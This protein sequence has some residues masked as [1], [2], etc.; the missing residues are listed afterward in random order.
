MTSVA[1]RPAT[2]DDEPLLRAVYASTRA[3][4]LAVTPWTEEQK[5]AFC[6]MQFE[7]QTAYYREIYGDAAS[8]DVIVVDGADAGRLYTARVPGE[9][10]VVDI[11]LLPPFR[12]RGVGAGLLGE[13]LAEAA[14]LGATVVIHV[15]HQNPAKRLYER[16]GF[17]AVDDLGIY[18]RMEWTPGG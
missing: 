14:G 2:P 8:Y 10:R 5:A 15:E 7:A 16:L 6:A 3:E 11:A 4:E 12:G 1:L 13:I 17:V 18:L 9:V